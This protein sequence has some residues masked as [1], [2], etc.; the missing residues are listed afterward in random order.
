M[1]MTERI[2]Q[3]DD[4]IALFMSALETKFIEIN[5]DLDELRQ[6]AIKAMMEEGEV[7]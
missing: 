6:R 5:R 1:D 7:G 4:S 3:I 2:R